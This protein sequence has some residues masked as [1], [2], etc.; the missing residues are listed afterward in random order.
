MKYLLALICPPLAIL[1]CGRFFQALVN[2]MLGWVWIAETRRPGTI[3]HWFSALPGAMQT[4][5]LVI[6]GSGFIGPVI[7][8]IHAVVVVRGET[9]ERRHREQ[10]E[11]QKQNALMQKGMM[12]QL[13]QAA[14]K[15]Q[16]VVIH[17][18]GAPV[19]IPQPKVVKAKQLPQSP[20][21]PNP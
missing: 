10:L 11:G 20:S 16:I 12:R 14:A 15:P 21:N 6:F 18:A 9:N 7:M 13:A 17:Q 8:L 19:A 3:H 5:F 2:A 1:S 4:L